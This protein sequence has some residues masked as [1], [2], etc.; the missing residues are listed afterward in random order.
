MIYWVAK[1]KD[2]TIHFSN[3]KFYKPSELYT[4]AK[5]PNNNIWVT[6]FGYI[7]NEPIFCIT[8][9]NDIVPNLTF[10]NSPKEIDY[11]VFK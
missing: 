3:S 7:N 1:D 6:P 4:N 10:E 2:G 5:D 11:F 9:S 8:I